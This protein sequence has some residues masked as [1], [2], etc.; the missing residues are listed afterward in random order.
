MW[1]VLG[2]V[3]SL[4][5]LSVSLCTLWEGFSNLFIDLHC[6][7]CRLTLLL[8]KE[9]HRNVSGNVDGE[10]LGLVCPISHVGERIGMNC[11]VE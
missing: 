10:C 3:M 9:F 1:L 6:I 7:S 4:R 11:Y 8:L 5:S 2:I